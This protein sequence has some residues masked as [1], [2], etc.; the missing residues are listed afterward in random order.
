MSNIL[1]ADD[2]PHARRMGET[3]LREEGY[4]VTVVCDGN[5]AL[6]Q[7]AKADPDLVIADAF[8]PHVDGL[9][10]CRAA[11]ARLAHV[12]VILTAGSL[13]P[14]DESAARAAGADSTLRKPFE[15]SVMTGAVRPLMEQAAA[16]R[17]AKSGAPQASDAE[18][19]RRHV[20]DAVE[21][22]LPRII[23]EVTRRVMRELER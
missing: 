10:L 3:I 12:R 18:T 5:A 14:F 2:S 20:T 22:E 4:R 9:A 7:L 1:L 8:L 19:I 11:K 23:D 6:E 13:E 17:R 15:A 16:A 21:A